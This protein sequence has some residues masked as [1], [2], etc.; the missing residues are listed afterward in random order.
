M[1]TS[2]DI[3]KYGEGMLDV[4]EGVIETKHP[5]TVPYGTRSEA[6][7]GRLQ[8]YGLV[9]ALKINNHSMAEEASRLR[10]RLIGPR[11]NETSLL[12][13]IPEVNINNDFYAAIAAKH[14]ADAEGR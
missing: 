9:R 7:T 12:I 5:A 4:L 1:P 10:F 8:F 13:E 2:V 14:R 3:R 11:G 6:S